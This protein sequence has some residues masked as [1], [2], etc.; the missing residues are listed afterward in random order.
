MKLFDAEFI[1]FDL[2][3]KRYIRLTVVHLV[4]SQKFG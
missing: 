3:N 1:L 2:S 4:H